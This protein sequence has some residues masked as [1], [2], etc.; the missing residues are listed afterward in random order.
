M[1]DTHQ[2]DITK[3]KEVFEHK[4]G[5]YEYNLRNMP[6]TYTRDDKV[7]FQYKRCIF[8]PDIHYGEMT[9]FKIAEK[10]G[11]PCCKA[12]LLKRPYLRKP[13]LFETGVM[14]YFSLS[15]EDELLSPEILISRYCKE[16]GINNDYM[17]DIDTIFEAISQIFLREKRPLSEFLK[18][19]KDFIVMLMFDLKFGNYDRGLNNW[20]LRKNKK[21]GELDLY[22][23]FDNEAI[24]G[25][26]DEVLDEMSYSSIYNFNQ[27][28]ISKVTIARDRERREYTNFE[29]M[30]RYLL[31]R[32]PIETKHAKNILDRFTGN[33]LSEI[34]NNLPDIS[35]E[36][37]KFAQRNYGFRNLILERIYEDFTKQKN[38]RLARNPV[39]YDDRM[40]G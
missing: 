16:K 19:K 29:D 15:S 36:R 9:A 8:E 3:Y 22:P 33:D 23:M 12:E 26:A 32:Y 18:F 31:E 10:L 28:R 30:F 25:F 17:A 21:T 39:T 34:L 14:S 38:K 11:I 7:K 37:K 13:N 1:Y 20:I 40:S 4:V 5:S 35:D 24:L 2:I 27:E 6:D